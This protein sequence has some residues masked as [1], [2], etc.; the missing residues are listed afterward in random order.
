MPDAPSRSGRLLVGAAIILLALNLR[1][2]VSSVGVLLNALRAELGMSTTVAAVL[3]SL[4]V[5]CFA[6]FGGTTHGLVRRVGLNR[7]AAALL[8]IAALALGL[9]AVVDDQFVFIFASAVALSACAVGN[10]ILPALTKAHFPDRVPL[11]S[12]AY[13]AAIMCGGAIGSVVSVPIADAFGSW[14]A[15]IGVWALL[16]LVAALTWLRFLGRDVHVDPTAPTHLPL[17]VLARS[18]L[19]WAAALCFG[20]QAAQAYAQF[21]WFPA[22]LTDGGLSRGEAGVMLAVIGAV[23]MPVTLSMPLLVRWAGD[24][25]ILPWSFALLTMSGWVGVL[26]SPTDVTWL[27]AVLLGVGGCSFTWTLTMLGQRTRTPDGTAALSSFAQ[28]LGYV[29]AALGP[30][31]VGVLHDVT[32]AWTASVWMLLLGTLLIGF[33]GTIL[34]RDVYLEDTLPPRDPRA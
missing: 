4:P 34:N 25:P 18:R 9:R 20:F 31:G 11:M 19:A 23:G 22:I 33:F 2:A 13:G 27:W 15:G 12:A 8:T 1:E 29:V 10:V 6:V 26:T 17:R 24:R 16:A 32:G 7:S 30:L 28:G 14:R 5:V 3:T 21:G